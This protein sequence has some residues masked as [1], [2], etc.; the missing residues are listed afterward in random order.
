MAW[1]RVLMKID[2]NN[3]PKDTN[4]LHQ[5]VTDLVSEVVSLKDKNLSLEDKNISLQNQL[6]RFR[7]QL[8]LLKKQ[9]FGKSSEKLDSQI[10]ELEVKIEEGELLEAAAD[11]SHEYNQSPTS[12][13]EEKLKNIPKRQKLP[14][15]L[16]RID[17]VL[18]PDPQ[19]P[20]CGQEEFRKISDDISPRV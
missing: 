20:D 8:A 1:Y 19:C 17:E 11:K 14:E 6:T 5:I 15:H 9:R 3:L 2:L 4:L 7:E 16:E 18:N 13:A 12:A 10:A